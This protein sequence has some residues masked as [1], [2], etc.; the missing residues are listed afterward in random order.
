LKEERRFC[1]PY[2]VA[3]LPRWVL[4]GAFL[5]DEQWRSRIAI[6]PGKLGGIPFQRS[7]G[8]S[9]GFLLAAD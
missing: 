2:L 1:S 9:D 8:S 3:A 4:T 5:M 6:K 7:A